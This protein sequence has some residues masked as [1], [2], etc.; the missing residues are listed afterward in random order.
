VSARRVTG[1]LEL[2]Q[3][4]GGRI[5]ILIRKLC[6]VTMEHRPLTTSETAAGME[7]CNHMRDCHAGSALV[8]GDH[9]RSY[10]VPITFTSF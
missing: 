3:F 5:S 9:T 2:A 6:D 8:I 1:L 10:Q 4:G 7:A